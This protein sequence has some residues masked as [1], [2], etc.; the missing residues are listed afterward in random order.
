LV[1]TDNEFGRYYDACRA[2][3]MRHN[4][5]LKAVARKRLKVIF[6]VMRDARPCARA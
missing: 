5:A 2:R 4:K 1:G 3:G 6:A